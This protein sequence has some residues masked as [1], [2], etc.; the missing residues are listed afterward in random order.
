[1]KLDDQRRCPSRGWEEALARF[2]RAG[3]LPATLDFVSKSEI[4]RLGPFAGTIPPL[5]FGRGSQ[6]NRPRTSKA[7]PKGR[8]GG[9]SPA[10]GPMTSLP[11][12]LLVGDLLQPLDDLAVELFLDGDVGHRRGRRRPVPVLLAGREPDHVA[13]PDLLD[14][15]AFALGPAAARGDD[16]GLAERMRVPC[17]PR[18]R[19]DGEAG[20]LNARRLGR[21]EERIDPHGAGEPIRR[22]PGGGLRADSLDVHCR[23]SSRVKFYSPK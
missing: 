17:G 2:E 11:A 5:P 22:S 13:G 8:Q 15:S 14:R 16:E 4:G 7:S 20:A 10:N 3:I 1:M 23:G 9:S 6:G 21:L 18:A 12:I 19:L